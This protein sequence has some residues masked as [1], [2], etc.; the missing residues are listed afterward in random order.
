MAVKWNRRDDRAYWATAYALD[1]SLIHL[2]VEKVPEGG[3]DWAAWRNAQ[4]GD[5][6]SGASANAFSAMA[7][8]EGAAALMCQSPRATLKGIKRLRRPRAT[9]ANLRAG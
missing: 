8:A 5:R 2:V 6:H 4:P 9:N 3:W 7:F 1:G